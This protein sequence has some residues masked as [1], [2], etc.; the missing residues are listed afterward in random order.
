MNTRRL[1]LLQ[2]NELEVKAINIHKTIKNFDPPVDKAGDVNKTQFQK[3]LKVKIGAKVILTYNVDTCDG[4]TNGARG[5]LIGI[6]NDAK[7]NIF[8]MIVKFEK[9]S[10]GKERRRNC[11][12]I[13]RKFP[14]GTPI[15]KVNFSYSIS[16]SKK[17]LVNTAMVIQFPLKLAFGC[18]S[19]KIQGST[20]PKPNKVII[21]TGDAF[22]PAMIYVMLSR[23]CAL[24]Q[25]FILNEFDE[26]KM[27]PNMMALAELERLNRISLNHNP[28]EWEKETEGTIKI[29]SLNC[30]S[31]KKHY[32]DIISDDLLMRSDVIILQETWLHDDTS[33]RNFAIPGFELHLNSNGR[34]KGLAT[35]YKKSLISQVKDIKE[36]NYQMSKLSSIGIDIFSI[37]RSQNGNLAD[38]SQYIQHMVT[39]DKPQLIIGDL[40]YCQSQS[41]LNPLQLFLKDNQFKNL[42]NEPTH[43]EGNIL[44]Q[45]HLQDLKRDLTVTA[46]LHH[47]YYTDHKA[48]AIIIKQRE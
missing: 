7:G 8:K 30:R 13:Q 42:I 11:P 1:R 18:T 29:Y 41:Q 15:D 35:Y 31:L 12:D 14:G 10:V 38:L 3:I 32:Q 40:N 28:T 5:E 44:D 23:V 43:M 16:R 25:I 22:G 24:L 37:Y 9:D 33:P 6:I 19:H 17:V 2:G 39:P 26:S 48:L 47:K 45:A 21:N 4:L 46:S 20:I 27:F 34:G 36:N